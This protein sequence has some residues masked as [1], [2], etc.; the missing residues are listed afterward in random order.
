MKLTNCKSKARC[1]AFL[2][3][4]GLVIAAVSFWAGRV[5][6][7]EP[8]PGPAV[9]SQPDSGNRLLAE[10]YWRLANWE[11]LGPGLITNPDPG[12][13]GPD[14]FSHLNHTGPGSDY[15]CVDRPQPD[16]DQASEEVVESLRIEALDRFNVDT[17]TLSMRV[18]SSYVQPLVDFPYRATTP[19]TCRS[20]RSS[21]A[22]DTLRSKVDSDA[23]LGEYFRTEN[24]SDYDYI[25]SQA[26]GDWVLDLETLA[27]NYGGAFFYEEAPD[28]FNVDNVGIGVSPVRDSN[29]LGSFSYQP[30]TPQTCR[31]YLS[32]SSFSRTVVDRL[33]EENAVDGQRGF[34][35]TQN[36]DTG[37]WYNYESPV[38]IDP[39]NQGYVFIISEGCGDW[40]RVGVESPP[41]SNQIFD[42]PYFSGPFST[43]D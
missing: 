17:K 2:V 30:T 42:H 4:V 34:G 3:V 20:T 7:S 37:G 38:A 28:R 11:Q 13:C 10:N 18:V 36:T 41:N 9:S 14:Q 31:Y 25:I 27:D 16:P 21:R 43:Y 15:S 23:S 12:N 33:F 40:T 32:D 26:C 1:V 24:I 5:S 29:N 19:E 6:V 22:A 8:A 35:F 39:A